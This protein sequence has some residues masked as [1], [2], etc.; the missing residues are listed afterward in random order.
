LFVI[1]R[2]Q[3]FNPADIDNVKKIQAGYKV[4]TLSDFL[5]TEPPPSAAVI[6]WI[7]PLTPE[8]QKTSLDFFNILNWVLTYCPTVPS[9]VE[10]MERFG[11]IGIG[12]AKTFDSSKLSPEMK[13]AFEDGRSDAFI[14][15]EAGVKEINEGKLNPG[16]LWGTRKS[17]KN[18]YLNRWLGTIGIYANSEQEAYYPFYRVDRQ[19]QAL[20]GF[21]KYTM[22]FAEGEYPPVN[23][24]WSL[25][26]Y[27]LSKS[28]LFANPINRYLIN[29]PMVP[30]M[31]KDADG[32]MTIYI[33]NESP[34][35]EL[36]PNWLPAPKG[37]F[38][39]Y[40]RL[41]WPKEAALDGSWKKPELEIVQK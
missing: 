27:V 38:T 34:G 36:E 26:M 37:P 7:K 39:M 40:M 21:N 33:Q 20:T 6:D 31:K 35:K 22:H 2:T 29:S 17:M 25:T 4:Q 9:E 24:F 3:L 15:Y 14:A 28:L 23:A 18:N 19:G 13:Q 8:T 1:Y 10:L 5:G 16:D 12:A 30:N 32:G 41:Y 11:K